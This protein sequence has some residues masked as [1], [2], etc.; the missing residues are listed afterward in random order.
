MARSFCRR[1]AGIF[2]PSKIRL[3]RVGG[4]KSFPNAYDCSAKTWSVQQRTYTKGSPDALCE[5][6]TCT[7][8]YIELGNLPGRDGAAGAGGAE[9]AEQV[10]PVWHCL[11]CARKS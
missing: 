9:A 7:H 11:P 5:V 8:D 10:L 2:R 6:E 3:L 1:D 4:T